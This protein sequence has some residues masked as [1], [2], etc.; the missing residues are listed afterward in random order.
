V[1]RVRQAI[2]S[3]L[4]NATRRLFGKSTKFIQSL[5]T[6]DAAEAQR[7]APPVGAKFQGWI[8]AA[9]RDMCGEAAQ[10]TAA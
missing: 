5:N 8:D 6:K 9:A 2:P 4:R 7:R 1:S 3:H 10:P